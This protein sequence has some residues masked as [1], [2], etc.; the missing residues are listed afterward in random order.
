MLRSHGTHHPP[1]V[2]INRRRTTR[3]EVRERLVAYLLKEQLPVR[4]RDLGTG[5]F[6]VETVE[7]LPTDRTYHVRFTA[8]DNTSAVLPAQALHCRPS[9]AADGSPRYVVGFTFL[10]AQIGQADR[11]IRRLIDKVTAGTLFE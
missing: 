8:S 4:V 2:T 7:P 3:Y 5:G 10:A 9:C 6:A 1:H 11:V